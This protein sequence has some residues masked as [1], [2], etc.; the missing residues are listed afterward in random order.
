MKHLV[1]L[2]PALI[3]LIS[4]SKVDFCSET[5][6]LNYKVGDVV[7]IESCSSDQFDVFKWFVNDEIISYHL[8]TVMNPSFL[9]PYFEYCGGAN[10]CDGFLEGKFLSSGTYVIKLNAGIL[11]QGD[12][13][14]GWTSKNS[15]TREIEVI[16][17]D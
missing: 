4:C 8:A 11:T 16:I 3:T 2:L 10:G 13:A 1:M 5:D 7:R 17:T 14:G 15:K 12:C 9:T 6:T